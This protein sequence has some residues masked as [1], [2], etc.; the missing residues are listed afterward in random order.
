MRIQPHTLTHTSISTCDSRWRVENPAW[1]GSTPLIKSVGKGWN[2]P[3]RKRRPIF[4]FA[5]AFRLFSLWKSLPLS[6]SESHGG[7]L[8]IKIAQ[9]Y[10]EIDF[11]G[12]FFHSLTF[13]W[14]RKF[15]YECDFYKKIVWAATA[16]LIFPVFSLWLVMGH[17]KRLYICFHDR[18]SY[19]CKREITVC[20][21]GSP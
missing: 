20:S 7:L 17:H 10:V 16:F 14:D 15:R 11:G 12:D 5:F 18:L 13:E 6:G 21:D 8:C 19:N 2:K 3:K 1:K 4:L 9:L